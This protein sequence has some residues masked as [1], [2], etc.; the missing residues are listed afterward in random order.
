MKHLRILQNHFFKNI[1]PFEI[2]KFP[3]KVVIGMNKNILKLVK[4]GL[5]AIIGYTL[6]S[7]MN[8]FEE[9]FVAYISKKYDFLV[10]IN[11]YI[12]WDAT[13]LFF[14][15]ITL[16]II[17]IPLGFVFAKILLYELRLESFF[18]RNIYA[19][20]FTPKK[21]VSGIIKH[22]YILFAPVI[23][24]TRILTKLLSENVFTLYLTVGEFI[25]TVIWI[26]YLTLTLPY[27]LID[28]SNVRAFNPK[29]ILMEPPSFLLN[30]IAIILFGAGSIASA[31]PIF[32][33]ILNTVKDLQLTIILF[34]Y[35]I[36]LF[37]L[38]S[39][40]LVAGAY[41]ATFRIDGEDSNKLLKYFE[42]DVKKRFGELIIEIKNRF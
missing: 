32:Y 41:F 4:L 12:L 34:T 26:L 19:I 30:T 29:T 9:K 20:P 17:A 25:E 1:K 35:S 39:L 3:K 31:I 8:L 42:S 38:P 15:G 37:Y 27:I 24:L 22:G 33:N 5:F 40:F 18:G 36:L 7:I 6:F 21:T 28:Y 10:F 14:L 23:I 16:G 2:K 13:K 11:Y